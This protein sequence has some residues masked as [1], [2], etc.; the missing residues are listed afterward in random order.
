VKPKA[1]PLCPSDPLPLEHT[2][3]MIERVCLSLS[4]SSPAP[5]RMFLRL[6]GR[7][8]SIGKVVVIFNKLLFDW[9]S[10]NAKKHSI[11]TNE[12]IY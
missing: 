8:F 7:I 5:Y 11:R 1:I 4:S 12:Y 9:K 2:L 6:G 3:F 10:N